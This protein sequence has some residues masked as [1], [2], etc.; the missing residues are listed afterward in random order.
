M[1]LAATSA[2]ADE[3]DDLEK[4]LTAESLALSTSD[5]TSACLALSSIRRAAD[6][7]CALEPG[8]RCVAAQAKALD[9]SRR[10]RD[11]CPRCAAAA[12]A[13]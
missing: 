13:P 10:V 11:A 8:P 6:R 3:I 2:R 5:C 4:S 1:L 7:L 12:L 9:A